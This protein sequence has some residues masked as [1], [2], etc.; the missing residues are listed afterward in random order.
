LALASDQR[1]LS[2]GRYLCLI[3]TTIMRCAGGAKSTNISASLLM[4]FQP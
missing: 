1:G 2:R 3:D 4:P